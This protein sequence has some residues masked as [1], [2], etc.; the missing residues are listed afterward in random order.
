MKN[1]KKVGI[2]L[3]VTVGLMGACS[4][5]E[6]TTT[7]KPTQ[8]GF[9][10][11]SKAKEQ[12]VLLKERIRNYKA[13]LQLAVNTPV[14]NQPQLDYMKTHVE[15][16]ETGK[17]ITLFMDMDAVANQMGIPSSQYPQARQAFGQGVT[18]ET[19]GWVKKKAHEEYGKEAHIVTSDDITVKFVNKNT[20]EIVK[21][22]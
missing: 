4:N 20:N 5:T 6:K 21:T 10:E 22:L 17:T 8:Q 14:K 7:E 18:Y 2:G 11:D 9:K 3:L 19:W 1:W 15:I 13:I 12:A 16:D